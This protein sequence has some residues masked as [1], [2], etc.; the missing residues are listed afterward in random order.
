METLANVVSQS[1]PTSVGTAK[2]T[3]ATSAAMITP[4]TTTP[5]SMLCTA[6]ASSARPVRAPAVLIGH[7]HPVAREI[8]TTRR[9]ER[10]SSA[11]IASTNGADER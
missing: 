1:A 2:T 7:R 10:T 11:T 8:E 6:R 4:R 9:R 3:K 5:L